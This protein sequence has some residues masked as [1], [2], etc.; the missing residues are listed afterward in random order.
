MDAAFALVFLLSFFLS[1]YAGLRSGFA[2]PA[3]RRITRR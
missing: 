3:R 1:A 2:E